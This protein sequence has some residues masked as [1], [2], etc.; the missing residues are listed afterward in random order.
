L[1]LLQMSLFPALGVE[2]FYR[3]QL[4]FFAQ[5]GGISLGATV[6]VET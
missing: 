6:A 4:L 5:A 2:A 1:L 3:G